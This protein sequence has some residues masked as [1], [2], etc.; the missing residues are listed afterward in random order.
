MGA[1][2]A[3][4]GLS[5]PRTEAAAATVIALPVYNDTTDEECDRIVRAFQDVHR[6]SGQVG[7]SLA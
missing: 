4:K 2:C 1:Y 3:D 5:L 6:A 7:R